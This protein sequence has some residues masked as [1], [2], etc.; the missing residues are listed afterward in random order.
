MFQSFEL[1]E[2]LKKKTGKK[3]KRNLI[4]MCFKNK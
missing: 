1:M 2:K 3:G 4:K